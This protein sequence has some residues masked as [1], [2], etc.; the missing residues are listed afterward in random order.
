[1]DIYIYIEIDWIEKDRLGSLKIDVQLA[2]D[3]S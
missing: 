2:F 1:M 3:F